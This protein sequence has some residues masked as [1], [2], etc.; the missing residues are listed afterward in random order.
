MDNKVIGTFAFEEP[1]AFLRTE[2]RKHR[3]AEFRIEKTETV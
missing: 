2:A 3:E 1:Y